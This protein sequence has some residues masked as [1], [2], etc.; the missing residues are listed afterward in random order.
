MPRVR[1]KN[2]SNDEETSEEDLSERCWYDEDVEPDVQSQPAYGTEDAESLEAGYISEPCTTYHEYGSDDE[3]TGELNAV[4]Q[5][6]SKCPL[7]C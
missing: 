5:V 2:S 6:S 4:V 3:E 1:Q 7:L